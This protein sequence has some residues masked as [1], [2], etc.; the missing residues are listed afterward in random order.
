[1]P[2][3]VVSE[4]GVWTVMKKDGTKVFGKHTSKRKALAQLRAL[5]ANTKE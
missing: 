5:Y 2:Y 1:M 4:N 3:M